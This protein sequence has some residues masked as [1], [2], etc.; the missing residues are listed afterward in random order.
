MRP[1][2]AACLVLL[3]G[4]GAAS[5]SSACLTATVQARRPLTPA[6]AT[7][8]T[9][10]VIGY[11]VEGRPIMAWLIARR[12]ARRSVL[13]V[14]SVAGDEPGG[15][16]VTKML[17]SQAAITGVRLWLLPDPNP[18]GAIPGARSNPDGVHLNRNFPHRRR[19]LGAPG[20]P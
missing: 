17:A 15:I 2:T 8:R 6:L 7:S 10:Y 19:P 16:A 14:G 18:D 3:S 13:V 9:R 20:R 12:S 1:P 4:L 5:A 11:S